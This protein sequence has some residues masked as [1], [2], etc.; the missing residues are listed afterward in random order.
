MSLI[1][2]RP[3]CQR[4]MRFRAEINATAIFSVEYAPGCQLTPEQLI[5][6]G[7]TNLYDLLAVYGFFPFK[8]QMQ[9]YSPTRNLACELR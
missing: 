2:Y 7:I 4:S 6:G 8:R 5:N 9:P 3:T 1:Y